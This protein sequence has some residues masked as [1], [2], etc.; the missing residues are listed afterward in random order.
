MRL[1]RGRSS[2]RRGQGR[3]RGVGGCVSCEPRTRA[4]LRASTL[5]RLLHLSGYGE[6]TEGSLQRVLN[7]L[8]ELRVRATEAGGEEAAAGAH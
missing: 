5:L 1:A 6:V 2:A 3:Q 8:A 7:H 4:R